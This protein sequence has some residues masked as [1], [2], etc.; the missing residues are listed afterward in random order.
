MKVKKAVKKLDKVVVILSDVIKQY[1]PIEPQVRGLLGAAR[2]SVV[3]AKAALNSPVSK[4]APKAAVT[5]KRAVA[6]KPKQR[7]VKATASKRP[8]A[9]A[10]KLRTHVRR[11]G[12]HTVKRH[13]TTT[14]DSSA[15][16]SGERPVDVSAPGQEADERETNSVS[17]SAAVPEGTSTA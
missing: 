14:E 11:K 17:G 8:S 6:N 5:A 3:R 9:P 16:P 13:A 12:V 4:T 2:S 15:G 1:A 7:G 10:K